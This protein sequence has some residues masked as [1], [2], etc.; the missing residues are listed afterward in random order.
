MHRDEG[1]KDIPSLGVSK[2]QMK[3]K[4]NTRGV[5]MMCREFFHQVNREQG[6]IGIAPE[7]IVVAKFSGTQ[8]TRFEDSFRELEPGFFRRLCACVCRGEKRI[9]C[10]PITHLR[11]RT[12][13]CA[14]SESA[15]HPS[16][17]TSGRPSSSRRGARTSPSCRNRCPLSSPRPGPK[18]QT[19]A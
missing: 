15:G 9:A 8:N 2:I 5:M 7:G 11:R 6:G 10:L 14:S 12:R 4:N 1:G 13:R 18:F 16:S 17:A 3:E 19:L